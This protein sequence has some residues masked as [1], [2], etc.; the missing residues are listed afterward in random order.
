MDEF[1]FKILSQYD[2]GTA[3]S[4][5]F[6]HEAEK[7][8]VILEKNICIIIDLNTNSITYTAT[9][10]FSTITAALFYG[11]W[12]FIGNSFGILLKVNFKLWMKDPN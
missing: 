7:L 2:F 9:L 11:D 5:I 12:L 4:F 8:F 3:L 1:N 6:E 10:G